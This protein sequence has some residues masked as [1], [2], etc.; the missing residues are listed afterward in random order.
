MASTDLSRAASPAE[1]D[2]AAGAPKA[3]DPER[4]AAL[5]LGGLVPPAE[6]LPDV[7]PTDRLLAGGKPVPEL[8]A[9]LRRIPNARNALSVVSV[10]VQAFG[11]IALAV[12]IDH[13]LAWVAAFVLM[14]RSFALFAILAHEAAHRLLFSKRWA[15][16][17]IGRWVLAYPAFVPFDAYRRSHFAH[18]RDELGPDEPDLALYARYPITR[19]S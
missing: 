8:R 10:L 1:P 17:F 13:P 16:D 18:H 15:N 3:R 19:D 6:A 2:R 12:W 7:L 14:G 9:E 11:V 5:G 4:E